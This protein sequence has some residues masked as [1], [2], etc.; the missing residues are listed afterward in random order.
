[1]GHKHKHKNN[2]QKEFIYGKE[3]IF[4]TIDIGNNFFNMVQKAV[5]TTKSK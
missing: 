4:A 3:P 1:M 2:S 5:I